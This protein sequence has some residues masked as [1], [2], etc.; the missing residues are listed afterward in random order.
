MAHSAAAVHVLTMKAAAKAGAATAP[1]ATEQGRANLLW[2]SRLLYCCCLLQS[3]IEVGKAV[4][5]L[6]G[7]GPRARRAKRTV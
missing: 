5:K 4:L 2:F 6:L 3:G 1:T 7:L